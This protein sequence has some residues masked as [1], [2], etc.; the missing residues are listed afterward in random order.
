MISFENRQSK[1][2]LEKRK[3]MCQ[4]QKGA[5]TSKASLKEYFGGGHM[6][7]ISTN[8]AKELLSSS[9]KKRGVIRE[10]EKEGDLK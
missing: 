7:L 9:N 3:E 8:I 6:F 5:P 4:A 1:P 2:E 10:V